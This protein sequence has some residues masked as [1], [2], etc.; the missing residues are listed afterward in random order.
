[1]NAPS[2]P[3]R[4]FKNSFFEVEPIYEEQHIF[5]MHKLMSLNLY[6]RQRCPG[7]R[8]LP[9]PTVPGVPANLLKR[10]QRRSNI[11]YE[12]EV[13]PLSD[14]VGRGEVRQHTPYF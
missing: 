9:P 3:P 8:P 6:C 4:P 13:H 11:K 1:M 2:V 7:G 14:G 10:R 12:S 5:N